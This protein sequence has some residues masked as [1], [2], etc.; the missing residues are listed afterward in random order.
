VLLSHG[1]ELRAN[2]CE[3]DVFQVFDR[4]E[5]YDD[6]ILDQEIQP[7]TTDLLTILSDDHFDLVLH[8]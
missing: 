8:R 2:D 3:V 4:L 1:L 7:M 6:R 5:I